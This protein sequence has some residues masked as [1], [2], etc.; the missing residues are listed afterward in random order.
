MK[1]TTKTARVVKVDWNGK[2]YSLMDRIYE[3]RYKF[4]EKYKNRPDFIAINPKNYHELILDQALMR[5]GKSPD[6]LGDPIQVFGVKIKISNHLADD[7][8]IAVSEP[9]IYGPKVNVHDD[10]LQSFMY[11]TMQAVA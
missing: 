3:T 2:E 9:N 1:Y 4:Y 5:F 7:Q 11:A 10:A 8:V 6:T